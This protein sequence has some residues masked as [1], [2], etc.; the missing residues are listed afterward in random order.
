MLATSP[1]K[2]TMPCTSQR[3][4]RATP[5][6]RNPSRT[7]SDRAE[8][9]LVEAVERKESAD[10]DDVRREAKAC[11]DGKKYEKGAQKDMLPTELVREVTRRI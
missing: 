10:E 2:P 11:V 8:D 9:S 6:G 5:R 7:L 3:R 4:S 1:E